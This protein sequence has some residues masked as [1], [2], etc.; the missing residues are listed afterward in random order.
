LGKSVTASTRKKEAEM[1]KE[2][3]L[4]APVNISGLPAGKIV[5]RE[6]WEKTG[7][8]LSE[9]QQAIIQANIDWWVEEA[10]PTKPVPRSPEE[11]EH[12]FE[13]RC[14]FCGLDIHIYAQ[15]RL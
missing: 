15:E 8:L 14:V 5:A 11:C 12:E 2:N 13:E 1:S 10:R 9:E 3:D 7:L 4:K 6:L